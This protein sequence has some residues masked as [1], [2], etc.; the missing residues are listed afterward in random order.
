MKRTENIKTWTVWN[1]S[2]FTTTQHI[3]AEVT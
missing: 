2:Y 3:T 1:H